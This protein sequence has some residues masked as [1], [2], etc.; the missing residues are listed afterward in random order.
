MQLAWHASATLLFAVMLGVF[1]W[2]SVCV[3]A[4]LASRRYAF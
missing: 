4:S 1:T 2:H 3:H